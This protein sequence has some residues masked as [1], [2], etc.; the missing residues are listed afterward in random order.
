MYLIFQKKQVKL[1]VNNGN[2]YL[3]T[4]LFEEDHQSYQIMGVD[5]RTLNVVNQ[6]KIFQKYLKVKFN[7]EDLLN[8]KLKTF[9]EFNE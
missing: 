1:N 4:M 8:A 2:I 5:L 7:C 3:K 6:A 9:V